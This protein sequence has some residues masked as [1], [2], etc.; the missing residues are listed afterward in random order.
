[1]ID[2]MRESLGLN[3]PI[4]EQYFNY[5][6]NTMQLD[7]G[8][9][10]VNGRPVLEMI[11][12]ALPTTL[13]IGF[14]SLIFSF[15]IAVPLGAT[16][17]YLAAKSKGSFGQGL[18]MVVMVIDTVPGFWPARVLLLLLSLQTHLLPAT[19]PV[20]WNDPVARAKRIA[21]PVIVLS[22]GPLATI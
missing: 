12:S 9:S 6:V 1:A 18:A 5:I 11:K 22:V 16:A 2:A 7:F 14:V 20:D 4:E 10:I 17:A 3:V 13:V 19:G 15:L 21:L 8:R